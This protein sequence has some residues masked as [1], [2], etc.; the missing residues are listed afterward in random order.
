[1][2]TEASLEKNRAKSFFYRLC[3]SF[4]DDSEA[5]NYIAA[6][7]ING[8]SWIGDFNKKN[9]NEFFQY[10][11]SLEYRFAE[12]LKANFSEGY[13]SIKKYV[14][15]LINSQDFSN[16]TFFIILD[17]AFKGELMKKLKKDLENNILFESFEER[18]NK[19]SPITVYLYELDTED[20][21]TLLNLIK[22][23]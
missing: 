13:D 17:F 16:L 20:R 12:D 19:V 22:K 18:F 6:N 5:I 1:M 23:V 7:F 8:K 15:N 10:K 21:K 14:E 3:N 11:E 2:V 4:K 9:V